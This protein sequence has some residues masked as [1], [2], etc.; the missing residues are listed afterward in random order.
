MRRVQI[1][2][3]DRGRVCGQIAE[4][5]AA[6]ARDC[7]DVTVGRDRQRLHVDDG[8]LPNLGI[9]Q[10][11]KGKG[12]SALQQTGM[13][14]LIVLMDSHLDRAIPRR[15]GDCTGHVV[16]PVEPDAKALFAGH[17]RAMTNM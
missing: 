8:V 12:E 9:D 4:D 7:D 1:D 11:A 15:S 14:Q 6:P 2:R 5:V 16:A 17:D 10:P 3:R 13:R